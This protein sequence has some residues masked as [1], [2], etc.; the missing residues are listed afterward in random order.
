MDTRVDQLVEARVVRSLQTKKD[1]LKKS[2][3]G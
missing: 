2:K 1:A 3:V